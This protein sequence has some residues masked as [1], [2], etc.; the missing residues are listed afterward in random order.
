MA[1]TGTLPVNPN[2]YVGNFPSNPFD[3]LDPGSIDRSAEDQVAFYRLT[4]ASFLDGLIQYQRQLS[5]R[6]LAL[7]RVIA[8]I[9]RCNIPEFDR[10][11]EY[12]RHLYR[13]NC[14]PKT[15][16]CVSSGL[17]IFLLFLQNRGTGRSRDG[18]APGS[19][20]LCRAR[21]RPGSFAKND[22]HAFAGALCLFPIF[23]G[24]KDHSLG[25]A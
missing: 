10:V 15:I 5:F 11:V 3:E 12:L 1:H 8:R 17:V 9:G 20:S 13:R 22:P 14:K 4:P 19:G 16:C 2:R 7:E 24:Q 23:I 18:N 6:R 21:A 25:I